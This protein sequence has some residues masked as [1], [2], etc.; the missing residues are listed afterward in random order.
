[1]EKIS[2]FS[3]F[4]GIGEDWDRD[5]LRVATRFFQKYDLAATCKYQGKTVLVNNRVEEDTFDLD[6]I[7]M[8]E[9]DPWDPEQEFF[10]ERQ[11]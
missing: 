10:G 2:K 9:D 7:F 3:P 1:M 6:P 4:V 8:D 5:D 11:W